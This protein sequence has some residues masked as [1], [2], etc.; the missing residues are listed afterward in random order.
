MNIWQIALH[1]SPDNV[2][3]PEE[4]ARV[5][6]FRFDADRV[7]WISAHVALRQILSAATDIPPQELKFI[8]GPHGKPALQNAKTQ[9]NLSHSGDWAL[10]AITENTPVGIDI[11][12]IREDVDVAP[13]LRRI[14][15]TGLP[16]HPRDL[17]QRWALREAMSKASGGPLME[18]PTADIRAVDI[19]APA[20]YRAAVALL[21]ATPQISLN[22]YNPALYTRNI[23][24]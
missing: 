17:F 21:G 24:W 8:Y 1:E 20:G 14:G 12:R 15:E 9:F 7:R 22:I 23:P 2:L 16:S 13:L 10:V 6:R 11:E 5:A 18:L 19:S 4:K 3:S